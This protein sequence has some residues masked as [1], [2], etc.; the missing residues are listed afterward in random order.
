MRAAKGGEEV[1]Q[2]Y[3]VRQ[4][5]SRQPQLPLVALAAEEVV[6]PDA[7]IKQVP[8]RNALGILLVDPDFGEQSASLP[9]RYERRV[10][11]NF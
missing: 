8:R 11:G 6:V 7:E 4:V 9:S 2:G 1:V 5:D 10:T 3:L